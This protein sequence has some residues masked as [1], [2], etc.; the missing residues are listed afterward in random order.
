MIGN[1][2]NFIH[3][4]RVLMFVG[5]LTLIHF[6]YRNVVR[7]STGSAANLFDLDFVQIYLSEASALTHES[8]TNEYAVQASDGKTIGKV[9]QTSPES[10]HIVGFTGPTNVV[11][12]FDDEDRLADAE[13]LSSGETP[14]YLEK[15]V[16]SDFLSS[17]YGQ[18]RGTLAEGIGVDGVSGATITS[19]AIRK[20]IAHRLGGR[21]GSLLFPEPPALPLVSDLFEDATTLQ[22]DDNFIA[23][24]NVM[25]QDGELIGRILRTSPIADAIRG[26]QGP[27]DCLIGFNMEWNIVGIRPGK[28]YDEEEYVH[29]VRTD[30]YFLNVFNGLT[31]SKLS[32][33]DLVEAEVEGVSG[34][35]Y[36]SMAIARGLVLA[37]HDFEVAKKE[38]NAARDRAR[39]F[40]FHNAGTVMVVL[41]GMVVGM[42]RLRG[43]KF[44]RVG[45]PI[46]LVGYLGLING[47]MFSQ[48]SLVGWS[49]HGVPLDVAPGLLCMSGVA[50]LIPITSR[51]N[52]YCHHICPHGAAQQLLRR[53]MSFRLKIPR[54]LHRIL[55][56]VP[57]VTAAAC[58]VLAIT[59]P[60]FS[61]VN[62][63]PFN[64][65]VF[66]I[67]GW[68]TITI[69]VIGLVASLVIP[70]AYCRFGCPTGFVLNYLR[71]SSTGIWNWTD[72]AALVLLLT[73][74]VYFFIR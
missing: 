56:M 67:A 8:S 16:E 36:T 53:A 23:L 33:L 20:S 5:A 2:P 32:S 58:M 37:A 30:D 26:Y 70:M 34:A 46:L 42:T 71:R 66:Q 17:L 14:S 61:L 41:M 64:A 12:F 18:S 72:S 44:V 40:L 62:L 47:D 63:E 13:F 4:A 48:A 52:I 49:R 60:S 27:T 11:L 29:Y 74:S 21:A 68:A 50:L 22:A 69:A 15:M 7:E 6:E 35:T 9:L 39:R 73:F 28:T 57:P 19:S 24:T 59:I 10:D 25:N 3:A 65:Y 1:R 54:A 45:F 51:H 38:S 55:L 43:N 31:S